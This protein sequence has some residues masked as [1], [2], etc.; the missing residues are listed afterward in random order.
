MDSVSFFLSLFLFLLLT[1]LTFRARGR[2]LVKKPSCHPSKVVCPAPRGVQEDRQ[3]HPRFVDVQDALV[4]VRHCCNRNDPFLSDGYALHYDRLSRERERDAFTL[5]TNKSTFLQGSSY[6][7]FF[8]KKKRKKEQQLV[9]KPDR[10][11]C[12]SASTK[13]LG[14]DSWCFSCRKSH[15]LMVCIFIY[16]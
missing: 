5:G 14:S 8:L 9:I 11:G 1:T 7:R 10:W 4:P 6:P 13:T 3:L 15:S 2:W 12:R 16:Q